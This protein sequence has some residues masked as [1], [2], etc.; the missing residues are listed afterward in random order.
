MKLLR[1]V[2]FA[3]LV[4]GTFI[5]LAAPGFTQSIPASPPAASSAAV[6]ADS[7]AV[8]QP[9]RAFPA[10][11]LGSGLNLTYLGMFTPDA[12]FRS[13]SRSR[14]TGRRPVEET[15]LPASSSQ[16]IARQDGVLSSMLISTERVVENFE[17][18][19]RAVAAA[20]A[21][22]RLGETRN[23]FLTFAYGHPSLLYAPRHVVTDSQQRLIVSDPA[24]KAVHVLDRKG[25]ASFR[26]ACGKDRRLREPSGVAVDAAD[27]IYVADSERGLIV[28]FDRHGAF[29][30]Y[31]GNFR[32]E[33]QYARPTGIAIDRETQHIY[34][35][36]TPRH[37][38][39]VM[40]LDGSV[41]KR[42]GRARDGS[43]YGD[44]DEPTEIAVNHEHLFV[45]DTRGTRVH[46]MKRDG[47]SL[48]SFSVP[49]GPDPNVNRDNG[50]GTDR[51]SNVY[52]SSFHGSLIRVFRR[53]GLRLA[54]FGQPGHSAGE[55]IGPGGLWIDLANRLYVA[56]SGNGRVQLFQLK[57]AE[58]AGPPERAAEA[59]TEPN[60]GEADEKGALSE[61]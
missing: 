49:Q 61:R 10:L 23:R 52:I 58:H 34:L 27:N 7:S 36:D 19:A 31:I 43:G 11:N 22:T 35:L 30:R 56:D 9:V 48:G 33:P 17:P 53:D 38:I 16:Q 24:G 57:S 25:Q 1:A 51:D 41:I 32:G 45:L 28:V 26:I 2:Q 42:L 15:I 47:T 39:F 20:H 13:P 18:P 12:L 37:M 59:P 6:I 14:N 60:S 3:S 50:L 44:F 8:A 40:N 29:V 5:N 46:V 55:F 21:N 54:V 4:L